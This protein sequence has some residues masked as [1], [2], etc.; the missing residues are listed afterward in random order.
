MRSLLLPIALFA[1]LAH[2]ELPPPLHGDN[3][4]KASRQLP[5]PVSESLRPKKAR[6]TAAPES[7]PS[8]PSGAALPKPLTLEVEKK[9]HYTLMDAALSPATVL[10]RVTRLIGTNE[11]G[12][13]LVL[14]E[15]MSGIN[16]PLVELPIIVEQVNP[17][18]VVRGRYSDLR[19]EFAGT[20]TVQGNTGR[21]LSLRLKDIG[22]PESISMDGEVVVAYGRV[23]SSALGFDLEQFN[24]SLEE[25]VSKMLA[26][27][28]E[29]GF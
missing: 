18:L 19:M 17:R 29:A 9:D 14:F 22:A 7:A 5:P 27:T 1:S 4:G 25:Q 12:Q 21:L 28:I 15:D 26:P 11:R 3:G 24:Q 16:L 13:E 20:Y 2:A 8:S 6:A 10:I 23:Q